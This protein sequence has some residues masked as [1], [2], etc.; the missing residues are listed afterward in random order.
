MTKLKSYY[1]GMRLFVVVP[2]HNPREPLDKEYLGQVVRV[3]SLPEG[4]FGIAVQFLSD[5][6]PQ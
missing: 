6:K 3:D 2:H 5:W 4:E 1:E